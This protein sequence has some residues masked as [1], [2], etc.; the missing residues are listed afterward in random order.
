MRPKLCALQ[1]S[2][3][4]VQHTVRGESDSLDH[5]FP[6]ATTP[7]LASNHHLA[8]VKKGTKLTI[9]ILHP[10]TS[11][12][13]IVDKARV[14]WSKGRRFGLSH[15]VLYPSERRNALELLQVVGKSKVS[16]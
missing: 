7:C 16:H 1:T 5:T 14:A 10:E 2:M 6:A 4:I 9:I 3:E 11:H 13:I 8:P 12:L 15:E